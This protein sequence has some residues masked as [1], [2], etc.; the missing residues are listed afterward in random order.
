MAAKDSHAAGGPVAL[1]ELCRTYWRSVYLFIRSRGIRPVDAEDLT[2][3]FFYQMLHGHYLR[4]VD[5]P[6]KGRLRAFLRVVLK[7]FLADEAAKRATQ[8][9]GGDWK[10]ISIDASGLE[11][12]LLA[13]PERLP[14]PEA[15]FDRQWA[16]DL[17]DASM[18]RLAADYSGAGKAELFLSLKPMLT[19]AGEAPANAELAAGLGMTEG[20]LKVAVHRLRQR[21]RDCVKECI[22]DTL[23]E[24]EDPDEELRYL[25]SMFSS[26]A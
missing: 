18:A 15:I 8:K 21:F 26:L 3:E 4:A 1:E 2:Q 23:A 22:C 7:R 20:A 16:Q 6:E 13:S 19:A 14:S 24:G 11:D 17:V 25:R 9:R 12:G 10:P 5:G